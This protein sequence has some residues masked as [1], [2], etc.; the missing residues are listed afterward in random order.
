MNIM[1]E[2]KSPET[3]EMFGIQENGEK[4]DDGMKHDGFHTIDVP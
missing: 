1:N 4:N 2:K 3:M